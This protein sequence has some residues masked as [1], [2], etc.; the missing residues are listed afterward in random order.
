MPD[1][2]TFIATEEAAM[3]TDEF[4]ISLSRELSVCKNTISRIK[5]TLGILERKH[6]KATD[7]FIAE[8]SNGT[9]SLD[10]TDY[11]GD[12]EAWKNSYDSLMQWQALE[13]EYHA[14]FRMMKI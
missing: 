2:T 10:H 12:F 8:L 6:N 7:V 1:Y 14:A 4:E 5:K 9:L 11:K 3:H 13:Q